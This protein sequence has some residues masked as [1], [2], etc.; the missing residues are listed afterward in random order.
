M[1]NVDHAGTQI[2]IAE[3]Q[4]GKF[5]NAQAGFEQ[6]AHAVVILRVMLI[7]SDEIQKSA[8][9]F[10]RYRFSGHAVINDHTCQF[11]TEWIL[12]KQVIINCHLESR[13]QDA[14]NGMNTAITLAAFLQ[15]NQ[16]YFC[17]GLL[18]TINADSGK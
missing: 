14:T 17:I 16:P 11:K 18:H 10:S 12:T 8:F 15:V 5:G 9:I 7:I 2:Y 1:I 6:D 3:C 4:A 13:T